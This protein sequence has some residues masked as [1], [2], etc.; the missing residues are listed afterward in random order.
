MIPQPLAELREAASEIQV[1]ALSVFGIGI[2]IAL[3]VS[4]LATIPIPDPLAAMVQGARR[5]GCKADGKWRN[6]F[7]TSFGTR[8]Q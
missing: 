3:V 5:A 8:P 1:F 7:A 6:P 2:L 4:V